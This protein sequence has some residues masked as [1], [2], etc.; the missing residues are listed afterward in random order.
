MP[1]DEDLS[2]KGE[3]PRCPYCGSKRRDY[4]LDTGQSAIN[5]MGRERPP[6]FIGRTAELHKL[7]LLTAQRRKAISITGFAGVGKTS[8]ARQFL[9]GQKSFAPEWISVEGNLN[10]G[11]QIDNFLL[12]VRLSEER[13]EY[14]VVMDGVEGLTHYEIREY[15]YKLTNY[16]AVSTVIFTTRK[17]IVEVG[18]ITEFT[19]NPL[20][21]QD[22]LDWSGFKKGLIYNF[23]DQ[24]ETTTNQIIKVV[25]PEIVVVKNALVEKLKSSPEDLYTITPRQFE[26]VVADL[27]SDMGW[28]VELTPETRDGGKDI[29]A[30]RDTGLGKILCLVEAKRYNKMRPIR[31][32]LVRQL[33]GTLSHHKANM[34]MLVTTSRFTKD[35]KEFQKHY[36]Y[37]LSL[38]DY[39]DVVSWLLRY[40]AS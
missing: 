19:L 24:V 5:I 33:Y 20:S 28:E 7:D 10:V 37:L 3:N 32:E 38:K 17:S 16:K 21:Q 40:K 23:D 1:L 39:G 27:L 30:Y 8:L 25:E 18:G 35:S 34:A 11:E 6:T 12:R 2:A 15:L 31:V 9:T 36:E 29:L 26:Q 4:Y 13:T 22:F 14:L